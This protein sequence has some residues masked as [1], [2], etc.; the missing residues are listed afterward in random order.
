MQTDLLIHRRIATHAAPLRGGG[1]GGRGGVRFSGGAPSPAAAGTGECAAT[2]QGGGAFRAMR[3]GGRG[4]VHSVHLFL[5]LDRGQLPGQFLSDPHKLG[6]SHHL[7]EQTRPTS[8]TNNNQSL[9]G[10]KCCRHLFSEHWIRDICHRSQDLLQA[11]QQKGLLCGYSGGR[12]SKKGS[13]ASLALPS[14]ARNNGWDSYTGCFLMGHIVSWWWVVVW[15][16]TGSIAV[17]VWW[18][19]NQED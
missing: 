11:A 1:G 19:W 10:R 18:N 7:H 15:M 8:F 16:I 6:V 5:L 17:F 12:S 14:L 9:L 2:G 4:A 13:C 3:G